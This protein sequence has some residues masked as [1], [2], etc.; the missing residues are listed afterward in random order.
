MRNTVRLRHTL[1]AMLGL[2][3]MLGSRAAFGGSLPAAASASGASGTTVSS[4]SARA[5]RPH[6]AHHE[7]ARPAHR[8]ARMCGASAAAVAPV[9]ADAGGGNRLRGDAQCG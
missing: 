5:A 3:G 7:L 4:G 2:A 8:P 1:L 9:H 6:D